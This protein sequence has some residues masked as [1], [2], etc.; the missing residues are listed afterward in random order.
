MSAAVDQQ[1]KRML[2]DPEVKKVAAPRHLR[3]VIA[4]S[5]VEAQLHLLLRFV[6]EVDVGAVEAGDHSGEI[7]DQI[8]GGTELHLR[9]RDGCHLENR[10]HAA[11]A[12]AK[13]LGSEF[14]L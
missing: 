4:L 5:P 9:S 14:V 8:Q 7:A 3:G 11:P 10:L 13:N 1:R 12:C 2:G 6:P